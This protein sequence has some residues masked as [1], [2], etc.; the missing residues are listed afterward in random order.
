MDITSELVRYY[1]NI[2]VSTIRVKAV[3]ARTYAVLVSPSFLGYGR[4]L[5]LRTVS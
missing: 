2:T 3:T 1:C 5:W 4:F